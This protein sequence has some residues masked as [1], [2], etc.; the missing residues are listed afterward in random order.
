VMVV[1]VLDWL[2]R[3][4]AMGVELNGAALKR[5]VMLMEAGWGPG[6]RVRLVGLVVLSEIW[7]WERPGEEGGRGFGQ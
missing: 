7:R 3:C 1:V 2:R 5:R 4:S 6:R